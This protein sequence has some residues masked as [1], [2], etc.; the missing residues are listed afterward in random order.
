MN[1]PELVKEF[2]QQTGM[3]IRLWVLKHK[4]GA[5]ELTMTQPV[6]STSPLPHPHSPHLFSPF[7]IDRHGNYP[8]LD[9]ILLDG[10]TLQQLWY[11]DS[12]PY[13]CQVACHKTVDQEA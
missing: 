8:L 7:S 13:T 4:E 9:Q 2:H 6:D 10:L 11:D 5:E 1:A 12:S 3:G